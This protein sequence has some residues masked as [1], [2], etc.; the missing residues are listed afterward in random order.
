MFSN[1]SFIHYSPVIIRIILL[2]N[3]EIGWGDKRMEK[4]REIRVGNSVST[5]RFSIWEIINILPT[6]IY[7]LW[8]VSALA[9]RHNQM[10]L[11][12]AELFCHLSVLLRSLT[13][14]EAKC[15]RCINSQIFLILPNIS[16]RYIIDLQDEYLI[17][18]LQTYQ[19]HDHISLFSDILNIWRN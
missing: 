15:S 13:G 16:S 1:V 2:T 12:Y 10:S 8:S 7:E 14:F 9:G 6:H 19:W 3:K 17:L 5:L 11:K 4:G 18:V